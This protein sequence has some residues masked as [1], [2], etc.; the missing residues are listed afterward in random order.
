LAGLEE[1]GAPPQENRTHLWR[2]VMRVCRKLRKSAD[3]S[4]GK[5]IQPV[6]LTAIEPDSLLEVVRKTL[7]SLTDEEMTSLRSRLISDLK[8]A[9]L[10]VGACLFMLGI[11]ASVPDDLTPS[12]IA[13]LLRYVRINEP[14]LMQLVAPPIAERFGWEKMG[15]HSGRN[16]AGVSL[17]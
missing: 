14:Q 9:R 12:D 2:H 16:S 4:R 13:Q 8:K 17:N 3:P 1:K 7:L 5:S 6:D 10:H 11:P 15:V